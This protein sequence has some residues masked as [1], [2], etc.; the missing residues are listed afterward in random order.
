MAALICCIYYSY[1]YVRTHTVVWNHLLRV[2]EE[3]ICV[4]LPVFLCWAHMD[5]LLRYM[6]SCLSGISFYNKHIMYSLFLWIPNP[7]FGFVL[8]S[9]DSIC[10]VCLLAFIRQG[11]A[12]CPGSH[13]THGNPTALVEPLIFFFK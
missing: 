4:L 12:G 5:N 10:F 13:H 7:R 6:A 3:H 1:A 11:L 9:G 8:F 2:W